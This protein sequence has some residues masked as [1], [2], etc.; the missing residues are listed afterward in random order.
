MVLV[1]STTAIDLYKSTNEE[2]SSSAGDLAEKISLSGL[3]MG[4]L[5]LMWHWLAFVRRLLRVLMPAKRL[6]FEASSFLLGV[7]L[8][9]FRLTHLKR[10]ENYFLVRSVIATSSLLN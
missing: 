2:G 4:L 7:T 1:V 9:F 10:P 3:L 8:L 5:I 6:F